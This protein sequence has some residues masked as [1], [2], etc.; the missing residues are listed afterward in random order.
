M[1]YQNLQIGHHLDADLQD[2]RRDAER[3]REQV[4]EE[5][6]ITYDCYLEL[7]QQLIQTREILHPAELFILETIQ[8]MAQQGQVFESNHLYQV[9]QLLEPSDLVHV[10]EILLYLQHVLAVSDTSWN[11]FFQTHHLLVPTQSFPLT[12][13]VYHSSKTNI[14]RC[15][16]ISSKCIYEYEGTNNKFLVDDKGSTV[17]AAFGLPPVTHENDPI[18]WNFIFLGNMCRIR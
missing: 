1:K 11:L 16:S 6:M 9:I 3:Q 10:Q 18:T 7:L 8:Q 13:P 4:L 5:K 15:I 2:M 12:Q 14:K 17:I